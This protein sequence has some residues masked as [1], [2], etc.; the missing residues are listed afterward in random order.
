M[1][2]SL[3]LSSAARKQTTVGEVVNLMSV[4]AQRL[5]DFPQITSVLFTV[6]ILIVISVVLVW[7]IVGAASLASVAVLAI[8]L[9]LNGVWI[10]NQI[11]KL[12]V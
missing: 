4:D 3:R 2:Q 8:L 9:P 6:P 1:Y 7:Q 10:A 11:R 5:Q 12:Q